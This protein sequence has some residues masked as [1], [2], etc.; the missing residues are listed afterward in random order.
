[1]RHEFWID[2]GGTFTDCI[3]LDHQTGQRRTIKLLSSNL[4]PIY[5]IRQFLGYDAAAS[6]PAVRLRIG[7]TLATNALL[8]RK[9]SPTALIVSRGFK[10]LIRIGHQARP[11]L[12]SLEIKT[13]EPLYRDVFELDLRLSN[14]GRVI[15][16]PER[17]SIDQLVK[18]LQQGDFES[19]ALSCIFGHRK[20]KA[21]QDLARELGDKTGLFVATG[22]EI[23]AESGYLRRTSTALLD[24]YLTPRLQGYL[25]EL[26]VYLPD[27]EILMMRSD[28]TLTPPERFRGHQAVLS[29]PAGGILAA[30]KIYQ[31]Q[32][33]A[34]NPAIASIAFDVGGTSTDVAWVDKSRSLLF[35]KEIGGVLLNVPMLEMTTIAAGGGSICSWD[36]FVQKVGPESAGADP[37]PLCYGDPKAEQLTITDIQLSLGRIRD[38]LFPFP[39][40]SERLEPALKKL[41]MAIGIP[42][43]RAASKEELSPQEELALSFLKIAI[44][45]MS[46]TIRQISSRRGHNPQVAQL[47]AYGGAAG[48]LACAIARELNLREI[49]FHE[50]SGVLSAW[51]IG[52]APY[53]LSRTVSLH[54]T[55]SRHLLLDGLQEAKLIKED[56]SYEVTRDK[57]TEATSQLI[58]KVHL[59]LRYKNSR[60]EA[61]FPIDSKTTIEDLRHAYQHWHQATFSF[62]QAEAEIECLSL[63]VELS[64][65]PSTAHASPDGAQKIRSVHEPEVEYTTFVESSGKRS[66]APVLEI[67]TTCW[68]EL[69]SADGLC[70]PAL[71]LAKTGTIVLESDFRATQVQGLLKISQVQAQ[72]RPTPEPSDEREASFLPIMGARF[73]SIAE[74]MGTQLQRCAQSTN[75]RQRLDF[76]CAL[77]D[78]TGSLIANAPHI[79]VHLGAMSASIEAFIHGRQELPLPGSSFLTNS[80]TQG[81]SHLPDITLITP[82]FSQNGELNYYVASRGHHADIG[83]ITPGSMPPFSHSLEEEGILFSGEQIVHDGVFLEDE[84]RAHLAQGPYPARQPDMV[85]ADLR[86]QVAANAKGAQLLRELEKRAGYATTRRAI[87]GLRRLAHMKVQSALELLPWAHL[88]NARFEDFM[89]DGTPLL[90][91]LRKNGGKVVFDFTGS[92][93]PVPG[94]SNAP[95]AITRAAVMYFLRTLVGDPIPLNQGC[96]D[97]VEIILP[98]PS[99]L[100]P[101]DNS[102]V[103]SGNVET[104]QRICDLLF[105]I[106]GLQAASQGTMNNFSFGSETS[107]YYETI[108]GGA[109]AGPDY[110]GATGVQTHMTNTRVSD[111]EDLEEA[112]PMRLIQF[113]VRSGSGGSGAFSGGD[114]LIREFEALEAVDAAL[115]GERRRYAPFGL[116]GGEAGS[117][118]RAFHNDKAIEGRWAKQ[119]APG[120]RVRIE[121]PGGGGY[122]AS[123]GPKEL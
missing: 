62:I 40:K 33:N 111:P 87:S 31:D 82:V 15:M 112:Y 81:G 97:P 7:T 64:E 41:M 105:G 109:G 104:S 89:D 5:A 56:L 18:S 115:I 77:F 84:M 66:L 67:E 95:Q 23:G 107:G 96:L 26:K 30:R 25:E 99:L 113:A 76:S 75:I 85:V 78:N 69:N 116:D 59:K 48:Q 86:A 122:G 24:A 17:D 1:M 114:G 27:S 4:A 61:L 53:S 103:V 21:E 90:L 8:E 108:A 38:D 88:N 110:S 19:I 79:P 43:I 101:F 11:E 68:R 16:E 14:Q 3:H 44:T 91:Q 42:N 72:A 35:E 98:H 37:G 50:L 47:L 46:E 12:F 100:S 121:T 54:G 52:Q 9:G 20:P 80:P 123:Q 120:D 49:V 32:S 63:S 83:G 70:G 93:P 102:A 51:G 118:G 10:D 65:T 106:T 36:G 2:R 117:R 58:S 28:G 94:N 13:P 92:G 34:R 39:L 71:L 55:L 60:S 22:A 45:N 119:L 29:G 73:A 6:L 74:Q 57:R